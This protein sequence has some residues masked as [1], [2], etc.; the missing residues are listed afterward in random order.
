MS[1]TF[2]YLNVHV[3]R[4]VAAANPNRDDQGAPKTVTYGGTTR[5]RLSSA[6]QNRA[7]RVDFE[8][9][10]P[11]DQTFR[12][13]H[14]ARRLAEQIAGTDTPSDEL[15]D[16]LT[17]SINGLTAKAETTDAKDTLVWLEQ[18]KIDQLAADAAANI[19]AGGDT[20]LN[21]D[22][23]TQKTT[24]LAVAAFGR[25]FAARPDLQL[26]AAVSVAHAITTHTAATEIDYFTAVDDDPSAEQGRGAGHIGLKMLTSGIF[27]SYLLL[28]RPQLHRNWVGV[29]SPDAADRVNTLWR[30]LLCTA[31]TGMTAKAPIGALPA[32]VVVAEAAQPASLAAAFEKPVPAHG[33]GWLEPSIDRLA[34]WAD[35]TI[36]FGGPSTFGQVWWT[37][38]VPD[39]TPA[40][41]TLTAAN[42]AATLD[43]L[44]GQLTAWTLTK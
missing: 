25:M 33:D 3:L 8:Q 17:R 5:A 10:S 31:P 23:L 20:P 34:A 12:S 38:T 27:Y 7:A 41:G 28:D 2:P 35:S 16:Y 9:N 30:S 36:S 37:T 43:D 26:E 18:A 21:F 13:A 42:K 6:S 1:T 44:L 24:A 39:H 29:E 14:T 40:G 32:L 11:A 4:P 15:V 22:D 19:A